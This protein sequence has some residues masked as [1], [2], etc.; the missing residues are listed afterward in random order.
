MQIQQTQVTTRSKVEKRDK[1][2]QIDALSFGEETPKLVEFVRC[3]NRFGVVNYFAFLLTRERVKTNGA[4]K[5]IT[6]KMRWAPIETNFHPDEDNSN[7]S[8]NGNEESKLGGKATMI[9]GKDDKANGSGSKWKLKFD[10]VTSLAPKIENFK[11]DK[12]KPEYLNVIEAAEEAYLSQEEDDDEDSNGNNRSDERD[13]VETNAVFYIYTGVG[14][15]SV[16]FKRQYSDLAL[17]HSD[18]KTQK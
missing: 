17:T 14:S 5:L 12:H 8:D 18:E 4:L 11:G 3:N 2:E 6:V 15:Q 9:A 10:Y 13:K 7:E 16:T 1:I